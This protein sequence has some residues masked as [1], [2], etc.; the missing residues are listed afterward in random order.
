MILKLKRNNKFIIMANNNKKRSLETTRGIDKLNNVVNNAADYTALGVN[1]FVKKG[2]DV[3]NK[4]REKLN[5]EPKN[6]TKTQAA[7][8]WY[9]MQIDERKKQRQNKK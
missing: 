7:I 6:T 9:Q 3:E 8:D 1:K 4:I 2:T 5:L